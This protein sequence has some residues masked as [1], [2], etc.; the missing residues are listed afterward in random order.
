MYGRF[1]VKPVHLFVF[2][3]QHLVWRYCT[4]DRDLVVERK[5]Y[6]SAQIDAARSSRPSKRAKRQDH[7]RVP[8]LLDPASQY[9]VANPLGDNWFPHVPQDVVGVTCLAYDAGGDD[10][11]AIEWIGEVTQPKFSDT[12]LELTCEPDNGYSRARN[13]GAG[14]AAAGDAVLDRP[15]RL[16]PDRWRQ[17]GH[18]HDHAHRSRQR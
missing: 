18:R 9:P 3:R 16:Q 2:T 5:T 1:G 10:P 7:D 8:H 17:H 14:S 12:E 11:P 15:A 13:R 4:A 6:F